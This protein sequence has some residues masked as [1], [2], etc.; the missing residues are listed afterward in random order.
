MQS[1]SGHSTGDHSSQ[2]VS[3]IATGF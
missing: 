3:S 1:A 2:H